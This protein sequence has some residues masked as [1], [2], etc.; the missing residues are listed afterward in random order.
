MQKLPSCSR[1]NLMA[2]AQQ[3]LH[4]DRD[5]LR[6]HGGSV[7]NVSIVAEQELQRVGAGFQLQRDLGLT[8]TEVSM[9]CILRD[10]E[11][12]VWKWRIDDQVVMAGIL[13][14]DAR[15]GDPHSC[16][17]ELDRNRACDGIAVGRRDNFERGLARCGG[18]VAWHGNVCAYKYGHKNERCNHSDGE[19]SA[20]ICEK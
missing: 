15:R 6:H 8:A 13:G 19:G 5:L 9:L 10:C 17:A 1:K 16:E 20:W 2:K 4:G 7:R 11:L 12:Y 3:L 14:F 18:Y